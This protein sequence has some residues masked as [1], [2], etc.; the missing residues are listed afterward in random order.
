MKFFFLFLFLQ[1]DTIEIKLQS[2]ISLME[3]YPQEAEKII[4]E[5]VREK[6]LFYSY[7]VKKF[8]D[9][10][11]DIFIKEKIAIAFG[12]MKELSALPYLNIGLK[13][14]SSTLRGACAYALG[15]IGDTSSVNELISLLNDKHDA[16]RSSAI[17][18]LGKIKDK[19]AIPYLLNRLNDPVP[20]C[21]AKAIVALARIGEKSIIPYLKIY[22]QNREMVI[23]LATLN[24]IQEFND[25]SLFPIVQ[26]LLNDTLSLIRKEAFLTAIKISPQ[27]SISI[28]KKMVNDPSPFVREKVLDIFISPDFP[29]SISIPLIY[30]MFFDPD[31]KVRKKAKEVFEKIKENGYNVFLAILKEENDINKKRWAFSNLR[32]ISKDKDKLLRELKNIFPYKSEERLKDMI[33]G[34]YK[35][36]FTQEEI[37]F[38][39]GEPSRKR[40]V[41][42]VDEWDY[43]N[44]GITLKFK[45]GVLF[46]IEKM[47]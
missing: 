16:V 22:S 8:V 46:K 13:S 43:D 7:L 2:Q 28:L 21:V 18:A 9:P 31:T 26:N 27:K 44:L 1:I 32:E 41:K 29:L 25:S 30:D 15:E 5:W 6:N 14:T 19:R 40:K 4:D 38:S 34:K 11:I 39:I 47:E 20:I 24:A 17:E 42:E 3:L 45:E 10:S 36:G 33:E 37:Y 12:R 23:R 35:I